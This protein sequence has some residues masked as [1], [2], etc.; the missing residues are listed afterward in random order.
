M[1]KITA[2]LLMIMLLL[3]LVVGLPSAAADEGTTQN[4]QCDWEQDGDRFSFFAKDATGNTVLTVDLD[5]YPGEEHFYSFNPYQYGI[6][7]R[8]ELDDN[9]E[10]LGNGGACP[11]FWFEPALADCC[12]VMLEV[13]FSENNCPDYTM[14]LFG[15]LGDQEDTLVVVET[16]S[17]MTDEDHRIILGYGANSFGS[18]EQE[19]RT[20]K[21]AALLPG[22]SEKPFTDRLNAKVSD[23]NLERLSLLFHSGEDACWCLSR[24]VSTLGVTGQTSGK[25]YYYTTDGTDYWYIPYGMTREDAVL[26]TRDEYGFYGV[27]SYDLDNT[28]FGPGTTTTTMTQGEVTYLAFAEPVKDCVGLAT[29]IRILTDDPVSEK[30]VRW[31]V[32]VRNSADEDWKFVEMYTLDE[33]MGIDVPDVMGVFFQEPMTIDGFIIV[34]FPGEETDCSMEYTAGVMLVFAEGKAAMEFRRQVEMRSIPVTG[35]HGA[36]S[37]ASGQGQLLILPPELS[38]G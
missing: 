30:G 18:A 15:D 27:T 28:M 37:T 7:L 26:Y 8:I 5:P 13:A 29:Y 24:L 32:G 33:Y 25:D 20:L 11:V 19:N 34:P 3:Q 35:L 36:D 10:D 16:A 1:K 14:A 12:G 23:L 2:M 38:E 21:A 31:A 17:Q 9:L 4:L 22:T 6:P